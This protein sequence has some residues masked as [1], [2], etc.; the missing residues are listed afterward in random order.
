MFVDTTDQAWRFDIPLR[1]T[2][3]RHVTVDVTGHTLRV[4]VEAPDR[5]LG[6]CAGRFEQALA[7][8][9]CLDPRRLRATHRQ[10]HLQVTIPLR[11]SEGRP[12]PDTVREP[13][14]TV[15]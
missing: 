10:G 1:G 11:A 12:S 7:L 15:A 2:D 14:R 3:P 8:P 5:G 13:E 6:G 9:S 4:R